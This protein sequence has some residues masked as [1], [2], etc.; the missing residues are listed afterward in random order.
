V[1][2]FGLIAALCV[3]MLGAPAALAAQRLNFLTVEGQFICTSCHEPLP[4]VSSPQAI[5]E[6]NYLAGLISRGE[7]LAQ[8]KATMVSYYGTAV[9][10]EPPA[11]GFNLL[12]YV[13]PPVLLAGGI[14]VLLVTLPKWRARGRAASASPAPAS[15]GLTADD[16]ARLNAELESFR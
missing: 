14:V 8:I 5:A 16:T 15:A 12:L 9:L 3:L 11:S 6:K 13:L 1:K 2:R 10:A 7:S 4:M